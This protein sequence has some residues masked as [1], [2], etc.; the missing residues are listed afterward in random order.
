MIWFKLEVLEFE[1]YW[2]LKGQDDG[3]VFSLLC[4]WKII[5]KVSRCVVCIQLIRFTIR[6]Y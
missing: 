5:G 6:T 3:V 4:T 2:I 1:Y